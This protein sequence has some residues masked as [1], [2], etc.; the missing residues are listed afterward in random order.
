MRDE[1][2]KY[3]VNLEKLFSFIFEGTNDKPMNSNVITA[4]YANDGSDSVELVSKEVTESNDNNH[5][6]EKFM[7]KTKYDTIMSFFENMGEPIYWNTLKKYELIK[8]DNQ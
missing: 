1:T 8:E 7:I 5:E 6:Y 3:F 2:D 4:T